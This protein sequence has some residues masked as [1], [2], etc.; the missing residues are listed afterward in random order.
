MS[1]SNRVSVDTDV[2][3]VR[4]MFVFS[5][6]TNN[7]PV[8][9]NFIMAIGPNGQMTASNA[10]YNLSTYGVGYLPSTLSSLNGEIISIGNVVLAGGVIP[11]QLI[12]VQTALQSSILSTQVSVNTLSSYVLLNV[13]PSTV[14]TFN[15]YVS[16]LNSSFEGYVAG[17]SVTP[18]QLAST[19]TAAN[20]YTNG[21]V[22]TLS[23]AL[24]RQICTLS[25][26]FDVSTATLA[27]FNSLCTT[28]SIQSNYFSLQM[29][30]LGSN[31]NA[32]STSTRLLNESN[33]TLVG[34]FETDVSSLSGGLSTYL[35]S[36]E[37]E[38]QFL[39]SI[40]TDPITTL[41]FLSTSA[42]NNW[43]FFSNIK[44]SSIDVR[45]AGTAAAPAITFSETGNDTGF[46][47]PEDGVI[48][49]TTNSSERFRFSGPFLIG[50]NSDIRLF[51]SNSGGINAFAN[52]TNPNI[53]LYTASPS[54]NVS[55]SM[56]TPDVYFQTYLTGRTSTEFGDAKNQ[57]V[58][59]AY[60]PGAFNPSI[61]IHS[62]GNVAIK[63]PATASNALY[64][65]GSTFING[66]L[67]VSTTGNAL[68]VGGS[69]IINGQLGVTAANGL[70]LNVN[71]STLIGGQLNIGVA[72]S[73]VS[74][75]ISFTSAGDDDTGIFHP[76]DGI[77][78]ITNNTAERF[79]FSVAGLTGYDADLVLNGVASAGGQI[80]LLPNSFSPQINLNTTSALGTPLISWS[81]TTVKY[82][83]ILLLD[84]LGNQLA[85]IVNNNYAIAI[86]PTGKVGIGSV[87]N[88]DFALTVNGGVRQT[89]PYI[90]SYGPGGFGA[91]GS[92]VPVSWGNCNLPGPI[93]PNPL[94]LFQQFKVPYSGIYTISL[95]YYYILQ[96]SSDGIIVYGSNTTTPFEFC[97]TN[98]YDSGSDDTNGNAFNKLDAYFNKDDILVIYARVGPSCALNRFYWAIQYWG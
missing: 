40:T 6:N 63:A 59:Y 65:N 9:T 26:Y 96:N 84:A 14:S 85:T 55:L 20:A 49:V 82:E 44:V 86:N 72:G 32:L 28:V 56:S 3:F 10:L 95:S 35:S 71:G 62:T 43:P 74:P 15:S 16:S 25:N 93:S 67:S 60:P 92:F 38:V 27:E 48:A 66:Q 18:G 54:G 11:A 51:G 89:A 68:I 5:T 23:T 69:T 57:L 22:S 41:G 91:T 64:V 4:N 12:S 30:V 31:F 94:N 29:Y 90:W 2:I 8:S 53:Q 52:P 13:I 88:P 58:T 47:H 42:T 24:G 21:Q 87:A 7:V 79:R 36:L 70:A 75:A 81:N 46:F 1:L 45:A 73:A 50:C 98:V 39:S 34:E 19:Y 17:T 61:A 97:F 83:T 77:I 78:A 80:N 76:A 37:A 33:S